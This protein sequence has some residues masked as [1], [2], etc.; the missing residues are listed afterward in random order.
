MLR[1]ARA[2]TSSL[3][4]GLIVLS[5]CGGQEDSTKGDVRA[6]GAGGGADLSDT[7]RVKNLFDSDYRSTVVDLLAERE[8]GHG[9]PPDEIDRLQIISTIKE[10]LP[11]CRES[12]GL[13]ILEAVRLGQERERARHARGD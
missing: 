1:A 12:E 13:T 4:V 9:V 5:G 3:A 7:C 11:V 10:A 6:A 8:A 2:A